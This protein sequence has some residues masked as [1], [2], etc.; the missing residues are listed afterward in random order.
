MSL[1]KRPPI[2]VLADELLVTIFKVCVDTGQSPTTLSHVC[3]LWRQVAFDAS[4]LWITVDLSNIRRA[5][6]HLNLARNQEIQVEW[7]YRR[8]ALPTIQKYDWI[9]N[10]AARFSRLSLV[11]PVPALVDIMGKIHET[12]TQLEELDISCTIYTGIPQNIPFLLCSPYLRT[13]SLK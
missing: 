10:H 12:L 9:W 13:L 3:R 2:F 8:Q 1:H 6:H 11:V 4:S 7:L 5:Q